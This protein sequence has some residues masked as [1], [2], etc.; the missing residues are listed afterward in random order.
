MSHT[1]PRAHPNLHKGFTLVEALIVMSI[2]AVL[3]SA[4]LPSMS[5]FTREQRIRA[6]SFDLV[7]DLMFARSEAI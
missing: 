3:L 1:A 6:A 2:M 5:D 4:A 7:S